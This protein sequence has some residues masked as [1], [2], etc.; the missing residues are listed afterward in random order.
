MINM[1]RKKNSLVLLHEIISKNQNTIKTKILSQSIIIRQIRLQLEL[2]K[3][4][5]MIKINNK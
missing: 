1:W 5:K 3:L 4:L 2:N